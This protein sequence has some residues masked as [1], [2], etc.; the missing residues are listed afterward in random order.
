MLNHA[1]IPAL[2]IMAMASL[3]VAQ[4]QQ[5]APSQGARASASAQVATSATASPLSKSD[6]AFIDTV[7]NANRYGVESSK[8]ALENSQNDKVKA[9][10]KTMVKDHTG[11]NQKLAELASGLNAPVPDKL[12]S[13]FNGMLNDVKGKEGAALDK[14]Y[15]N[16]HLQLHITAV[17]LF[18]KTSSSADNPQIKAFAAALLPT[19]EHHLE[20]AK[21]LPDLENVD[22]SAAKAN[23]N[24]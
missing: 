7:Y 22:K 13:Q 8:I 16:A 6:Q 11:A 20:M 5:Q 21:Q 2:C 18:K 14:A 1:V 24:H 19:L 12:N 3:S 10:A 23:H 17:N 4:Q 9:F 15:D